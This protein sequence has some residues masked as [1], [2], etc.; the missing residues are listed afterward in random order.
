[1]KKECSSIGVLFFVFL[2]SL[3]NLAWGAAGDL[4]WTDTINLWPPTLFYRQLALPVS[5]AVSS[6][7]CVIGFTASTFANSANPGT[8]GYLVAYDIA[9]GK[10]KWSKTFNDWNIGSIHKMEINGDVLYVEHNSTKNGEYDITF[11]Y[12]NLS[13]GKLLWEQNRPGAPSNTLAHVGITPPVPAI[14]SNT[15]ILLE[16]FN[17]GA[18]GRSYITVQAYQVM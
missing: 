10:R 8:A 13:T 7:T 11:G 3:T 1:M 9:T 12:Y 17:G 16:T 5:T 18:S 2:L 15:F 14:N 6:T 4:V